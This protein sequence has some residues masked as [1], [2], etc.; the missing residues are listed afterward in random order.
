MNKILQNHT[1]MKYRADK[2]S[3]TVEAA[4]IIPIFLFGL[5]SVIS[6]GIMMNVQL[7]IQRAINEESKLLAL[8]CTD[9]HSEALSA[10]SEEVLEI[11]GEMNTNFSCV[12]GGRDGLDFSRSKID[13]QEYVELVA[14]YYCKPI[15]GEL[16]G[17]TMFPV[18]QKSVMHVWN[19]YDRGYFD[20]EC[21]Y[22]YITGGS[23]VYHSDRECSHLVLSIKKVK[24]EEIQAER[25]Q[26]GAK[27]YPCE[28][29]GGLISNGYLYTT[30]EGTRYHG[31][32]TCSGLKRTVKAV[33]LSEV[34]D[35]RECS[36]CRR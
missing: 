17:I 5:I 14:Y 3:F 28:L 16:L 23:E 24:E 29:C 36:R 6:M 4:L 32:I 2:G 27:Y 26:S 15:C 25:N 35:R 20:E 21:D 11:L 31:R 13:N 1:D 34:G 18:M 12:E 30:K 7:K 10:V 33:R 8:R 19:G 9:G 22:V